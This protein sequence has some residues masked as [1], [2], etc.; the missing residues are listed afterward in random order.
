MTS[1]NTV[2]SLPKENLIGDELHAITFEHV[3]FHSKN[4]ANCA[5]HN[6]VK[7]IIL[8]LVF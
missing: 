8:R 5:L 6:R 7:G 3:K 2:Q 4:M 1:V